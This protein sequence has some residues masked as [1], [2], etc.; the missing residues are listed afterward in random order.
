MQQ[1]SEQSP[2]LKFW[3]SP[4]CWLFSL[5]LLI[6]SLKANFKQNVFENQDISTSGFDDLLKKMS[7]SETFVRQRTD[8]KITENLDNSKIK[9]YSAACK[10][11]VLEKSHIFVFERPFPRTPEVFL[12]ANSLINKYGDAGT[13]LKL[14]ARVVEA[15]PANVTIKVDHQ[16]LINVKR[17]KE[18]FSVCYL[19]IMEEV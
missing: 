12:V 8:L 10:D 5:D 18:P 6:V 11:L 19:A 17:P 2:R 16:T 15:N 9:Y 4:F 3:G 14:Q 7:A 13:M 1:K